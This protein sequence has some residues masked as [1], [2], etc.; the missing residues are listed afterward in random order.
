MF[1][2]IMS[3]AMLGLVVVSGV[4]YTKTMGELHSDASKPATG[5][6]RA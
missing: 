3:L 4:I 5:S 6:P 1:T 2:A